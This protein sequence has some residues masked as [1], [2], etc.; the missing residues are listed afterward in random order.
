MSPKHLYCYANEAIMRL[1]IG[2]VE[3]DAIGR[4]EAFA[5]QIESRR[6]SYRKLTKSL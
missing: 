2:N 5:K 1:N 6:I 4:M 3:V